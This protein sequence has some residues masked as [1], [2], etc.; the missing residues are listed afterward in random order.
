MAMKREK[1]QDWIDRLWRDCFNSRKR[2]APDWGVH[3]SLL[4][5]FR[6]TLDAKTLTAQAIDHKASVYDILLSA[7]KEGFI[8]F[9]QILRFARFCR[10][11]PQMKT[12]ARMVRI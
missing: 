2:I 5:G 10:G 3:P 12:R 9:A 4:D 6:E 7:E 11:I 8:E 1:G